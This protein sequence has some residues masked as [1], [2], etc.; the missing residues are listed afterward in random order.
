MGPFWGCSGFPEC[1]TTLNDLHGKPSNQ[2]DDTFRCPVCTRKLVKAETGYWF[3]SGYSKG[4]KIKVADLAGKPAPSFRCGKCGNLLVS[5]KGK[6]GDFWGC[7][8]FPVCSATYSDVDGR[9]DF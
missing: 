8:E 1:K 4:C 2:I 5:R 6:N 7:S 9:P 3:C